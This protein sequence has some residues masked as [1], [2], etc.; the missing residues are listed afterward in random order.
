MC[1]FTGGVLYL[2]GELCLKPVFVFYF[3]LIYFI[4]PSVALPLLQPIQLAL[5]AANQGDQEALSYLTTVGQ[6][7][8]EEDTE[9][10]E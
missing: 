10:A 3:W 9:K 1:I 6:V 5:K 8:T 4:F 7:E 2:V